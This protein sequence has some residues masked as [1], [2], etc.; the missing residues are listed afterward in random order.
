[1]LIKSGKRTQRYSIFTLVFAANFVL[2]QN[3]M[4]SPG[5]N[6]QSGLHQ[7]GEEFSVDEN[8]LNPDPDSIQTSE[9]QESNKAS[10]CAKEGLLAMDIN[11][12]EVSSP[13]TFQ[14]FQRN[15][16]GDNSYGPIY[17]AGRIRNG[18]HVDCVEARFEEIEGGQSSPWIRLN[19]AR[20]S[21]NSLFEFRLGVRQ[22]YYKVF[23]RGTVGMYRTPEILVPR[24]GVGEVFITAGQSNSSFAGDVPQV[25]TSG[26]VSYFDGTDWK[27]CADSIY[28]PSTGANLSAMGRIDPYSAAGNAGL[29]GQGRQGGSYW[30]ILGDSLWA[31]WRVPIAFAPVGVSGTGIHNWLPKSHPELQGTAVY[32]SYLSTADFI[33][34]LPNS[35]PHK[36]GNNVSFASALIAGAYGYRN[37]DNEISNP[38]ISPPPPGGPWVIE[39]DTQNHCPTFYS[40]P[41]HYSSCM[42]PGFLFARLVARMKQL[43]KQGGLRAVLWHQGESD[44][45]FQDS[46]KGSNSN[47]YSD[48]LSYLI[49]ESRSQSGNSQLPW[50]V[51]MV[52]VTAPQWRPGY[53]PKV[54]ETLFPDSR[55][56]YAENTMP[57]R[58]DVQLLRVQQQK[59]IE[60]KNGKTPFV[61]LGVDTD[62]LIGRDAANQEIYRSSH[63][64]P[65]FNSKGLL[66]VGRMW[67]TALM[68]VFK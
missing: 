66:E 38:F 67:T 14:I 2:F 9:I 57:S 24:V 40:G 63:S 54:G 44:V 8:I 36:T 17:F 22:G 55:S 48:L 64:F 34:S 12:I 56:L 29:P 46:L 15:G 47:Y 61:Y 42:R 26:R 65:H 51:S 3:C 50:F 7:G 1:M 6:E 59:V 68:S 28:D 5:R 16:F 25:T 62:S 52:G 30:C 4:P 58:E 31:Y 43:A 37:L 23:I 39:N 27:N 11:P 20:L 19:S 13:Q 10:S 32:P 33:K 18:S 21:S 49:S 35:S 45:V 41:I 53:T 60:S